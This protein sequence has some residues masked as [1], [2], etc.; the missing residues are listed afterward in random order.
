[1]K[2]PSLPIVSALIAM[3][4]PILISIINQ[5]GPGRFYTFY[6]INPGVRS[7]NRVDYVYR[8]G[9]GNPGCVTNEKSFCKA[10]W[11]Q[12]TIPDCDSSPSKTAF[13]YTIFF[14]E[15]NFR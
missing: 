11:I 9:C 12:T 4:G 10:V 3:S 7:T 14:G 15:Y 1:M 2:L 6:N 8:T 5:D 13:L